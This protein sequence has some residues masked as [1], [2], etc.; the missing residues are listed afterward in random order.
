[1]CNLPW[2]HILFNFLLILCDFPIMHSGPT[3][4]PTPSYP[5]S[6]LATSLPK[7]IKA[8]KQINKTNIREYILLWKLLCV[9]MC[10]TGYPAVHTSSLANLHC[11]ESLIWFEIAGFCNTF[12]T[13]S[14]LELFLVILLLPCVSEILQLWISRAHPIMCSNSSQM[15]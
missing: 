14:S 7:K 1:M 4:L 13:G 9:T 10:P 15:M 5:P 8:H 12:S 3:H 11:N 6:T 2:S